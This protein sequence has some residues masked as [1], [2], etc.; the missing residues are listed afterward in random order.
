[1]TPSHLMLFTRNVINKKNEFV[2]QIN[3]ENYSILVVT[4]CLVII[5]LSSVKNIPYVKT[6]VKNVSIRLT[7]LF[8]FCTI[9]KYNL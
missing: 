8:D 9:V 7:S 4:R 5:I 3:F 2:R 6:R 1:M